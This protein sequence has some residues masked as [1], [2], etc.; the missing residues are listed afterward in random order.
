MNNCFE[1]LS[2]SLDMKIRVLHDIEKYNEEQRKAFDADE[3]DFESFDEAIEKKEELIT[4]LEKLDEGF[5]TLYK[6]LES[7]IKI[8]K[9]KYADQ[10][11][12]IQNKIAEITDLSVS[13]QASEARNKNLVEQYFAKAKQGI[14]KN[15]ISSR[16]AYD[17]YK[18]MS[19]TGVIGAQILDSK[20]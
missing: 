1:I 17:Y 14:K 12:L 4:R 18:N 7:E 20:N 11:K 3:P 13:V 10:I 19:G 6:E 8:N 9:Q 5:E 15:R 16:V 2:E